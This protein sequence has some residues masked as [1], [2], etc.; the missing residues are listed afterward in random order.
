[1]T[2]DTQKR[3]YMFRQAELYVPAATRR[4]RHGNPY[5]PGESEVI[6]RLL[7][8]NA[9]TL[10]MGPPKIAFE[11]AIPDTIRR[12]RDSVNLL[13]TPMIVTAMHALERHFGPPPPYE[14]GSA[15]A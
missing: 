2:L 14:P 13:E 1:M 11:K 5:V 7:W 4:S 15:N 10:Y 6:H 3:N 8:I 9:L 12:R